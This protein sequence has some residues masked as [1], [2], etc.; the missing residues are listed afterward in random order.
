MDQAGEGGKGVILETAGYCPEGASSPA[1]ILTSLWYWGGSAGTGDR[2][3][4]VLAAQGIQMG[5]LLDVLRAQSPVAARWV[6][7]RL[8]SVRHSQPRAAPRGGA[9]QGTLPELGNNWALF[10]AVMA[11][12]HSLMHTLTPDLFSLRACWMR[13]SC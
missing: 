3:A 12:L 10:E 7:G 1:L 5:A 2:A 13:Q 9:V 6:C 4:A 8:S 11:E